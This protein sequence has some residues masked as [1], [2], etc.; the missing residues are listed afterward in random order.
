M[1]TTPAGIIMSL[2][3]VFGA[4]CGYLFLAEVISF[5][6]FVGGTLML[7]AMILA[8]ITLPLPVRRADPKAPL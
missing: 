4:L 7:A 2:E 5:Q 1:P 6:M 3:A 8:Q